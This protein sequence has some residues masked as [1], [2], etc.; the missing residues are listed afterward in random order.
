MGTERKGI[1]GL[2]FSKRKRFKGARI[3]GRTSPPPP[4]CSAESVDR[5]TRSL[6]SSQGRRQRSKADTA[7][8]GLKAPSGA[9]ALQARDGS[10]IPVASG[11]GAREADG[12]GGGD[13]LG[14]WGADG[15]E[16]EGKEACDFGSG[17]P[18]A[19]SGSRGWLCGGGGCDGKP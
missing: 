5:S 10:V 17:R 8:L 11:E 7:G 6:P 12:G 3:Q 14:P 4:A 19:G 15:G 2:G 18:L 1:P 9:W 16:N 13:G